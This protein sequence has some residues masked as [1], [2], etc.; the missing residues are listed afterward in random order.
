MAELGA[1]RSSRWR[2]DEGWHRSRG[3]CSARPAA[4]N[5]SITITVPRPRRRRGGRGPGLRGARRLRHQQREHRPGHADLLPLPGYLRRHAEGR[6]AACSAQSDGKYTISY[7][8]LPLGCRRP[9]AATRPPAGRQGP[10]A[11]TS[12]PGRHLGGRVRR[13]GLDP[14]VDRR[15]QAAGRERTRCKPMLETATGTASSTRCPTTPT[16]SCCGTAPTW[17]RPRRPPGPQMIADAEQLAKAG[18]PH[19]IEIQG[20]QYEGVDRLVQ[21]HAGQRGR[22]RPDAGCASTCRWARPPS[23]R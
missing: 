11:S 9:A 3:L 7:Q 15:Q 20:A 16:P 13:G 17:C 1:G 4:A 8:Q 2:D 12:G 18:K 5:P 21:H 10:H 19:L 23:R 6:R 14:A 22:Q